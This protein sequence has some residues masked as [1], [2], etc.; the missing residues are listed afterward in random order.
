MQSI[1]GWVALL[2][3]KKHFDFEAKFYSEKIVTKKKQKKNTPVG[4]SLLRR[5]DGTQKFCLRYVWSQV[6]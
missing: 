2:T 6:L 3:N 1:D 4:C 5:I